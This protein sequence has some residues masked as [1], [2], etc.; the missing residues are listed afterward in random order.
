MKA[1]F[2]EIMGFSER[3]LGGEVVR[4]SLRGWKLGVVE[5]VDE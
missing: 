3:L 2:R 5:V 4:G 1:R